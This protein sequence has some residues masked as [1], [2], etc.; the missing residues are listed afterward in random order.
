MVER[1]HR[2]QYLLL[3]FVLFYLS[4]HKPPFI[5]FCWMV[6]LWV[7]LE[8]VVAVCWH[9]KST[10]PLQNCIE[11]AQETWRFIE[12]SLALIVSLSGFRLFSMIFAAG[13]VAAHVKAPPPVISEHKHMVDS[14]WS[15]SSVGGAMHTDTKIHLQISACQ[16]TMFTLAL[17]IEPG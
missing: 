12:L 2:F 3:Q 9:F 14:C 11:K 17:L 8:C 10:V 16:C 4:F 1:K 7:I 13:T 5:Y 6:L 15:V